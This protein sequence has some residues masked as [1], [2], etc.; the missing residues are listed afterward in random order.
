MYDQL[1]KL[2][3]LL[4]N[5]TDTSRSILSNLC[6]DVFKAVQNSWEYFSFDN[7]LSKVNGVLGNLSETLAHVTLELSIWVGDQSS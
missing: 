5:F 3:G 6:V 4:G 1:S 2:S 7:D